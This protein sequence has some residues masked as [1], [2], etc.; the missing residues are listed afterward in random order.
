ME[1]VRITVGAALDFATQT[2]QPL[3]ADSTDS[4]GAPI[5]RSE[6]APP[7]LSGK[8]TISDLG[9]YLKT[10]ILGVLGRRN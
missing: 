3:G 5:G 7:R 1:P 4:T 9:L 8:M 2:A 6:A 10:R